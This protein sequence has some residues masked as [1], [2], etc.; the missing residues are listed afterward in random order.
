VLALVQA[1]VQALVLVLVL[2]LVRRRRAAW[3]QSFRCRLRHR[4]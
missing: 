4:R 1:L 2:V 3:A